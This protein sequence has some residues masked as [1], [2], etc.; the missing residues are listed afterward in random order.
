MELFSILKAVANHFGITAEAIKS[1]TRKKPI[2][3]ARLVYYYLAR[4]E[5]NETYLSIAKYVNRM[6]HTT[7]KYNIERI[8]EDNLRTVSEITK[9]LRNGS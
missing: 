3:D 8:N 1:R 5:T 2:I 7:V 4:Q 6:N 9:E